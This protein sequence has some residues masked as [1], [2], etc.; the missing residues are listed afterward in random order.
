MSKNN[1]IANINEKIRLINPLIPLSVAI[2]EEV[3]E[4][5]IIK[6]VKTKVFKK[7]NINPK[8]APMVNNIASREDVFER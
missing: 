3:Y 6:Y 5:L 7:L 2:D 1:P 4:A 8:P